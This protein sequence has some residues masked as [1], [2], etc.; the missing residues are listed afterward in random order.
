MID[1]RE[2]LLHGAIGA[3]VIASGLSG[4]DAL[5]QNAPPLRKSLQGLKW[6]DPIVSA[7]RDA[8]GIMKQKPA[9]DPL[10][11]V[12]L[13]SI[14]GYN[15]NQYHFCPHGDWYF[16]PWHRA[17]V[18]MYEQVVRKLTSHPGFA[19]PYWDWTASPKMP[20]QFL[21]PKTPDGKTN[22]LFNADKGW[23][24]TWPR[25]KPM[26][27]EIVGPDVLKAILAAQPYEVFGTARNPQQNNTDPKWVPMG[28]GLQGILESRPHN[29]VHNNIG[30]WMP[31]ASSSRDPIFFMHHSNIDRIWARWNTNHP[32]STD[33]LWTGM[34]FPNNFRH[35]DGTFW[36]PKVPDL[37]RPEALGYTYNLAPLLQAA[38]GVVRPLDNKLT[39]LFAAP[40]LAAA[41]IQGV[42]TATS[43]NSKAAKAGQPLEVAVSLP[44][45]AL[46]AIG[47]PHAAAVGP[48]GGGT[49]VLAFLREVM[50]TDP[51]A[52]M[53]RVFVNSDHVTDSTPITDPHY[54]GTFG[55]F[56]AGHG[57]HHM[58]PS[59]AL[60]LT[61]ALQRTGGAA[62]GKVRL[63]LVAVS[64]TGAKAPG[65]A[66][67]SAV[68]VSL[69]SG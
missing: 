67:P 6:N 1:R 68:E 28:G 69:V 44:S 23:E 60:D 17:F 49:R 50:I 66:T 38:P 11:W 8:V 43:P 41:H 26:P 24:R 46:K 54:V 45:A 62:S 14:H 13:S 21:D 39:A 4:L 35:P 12:A 65:S 31:T 53:F 20:D 19:M 27:A 56:H 30:G 22:W 59:F 36:S 64:N 15:P 7:Y 57:D 25:N 61:D 18:V 5:A 34:A 9:S 51:Q 33:P 47:A 40:N 58:A 32:N 10:S 52:T 3:G 55:V 48:T 63:Q 37:F 29:L 2:V 16:L 42:T